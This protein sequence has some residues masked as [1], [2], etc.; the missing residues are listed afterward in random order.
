MDS[1][2]K[3]QYEADKKYIEAFNKKAL[4]KIKEYR[5][6]KIADLDTKR[7]NFIKSGL[8][9][10]P[11]ESDVCPF[12]GEHTITDELKSK[13]SKDVEANS[14]TGELHEKILKALDQLSSR[15]T[16]AAQ[17][18]LPRMKNAPTVQ[19]A[20]PKIRQ[21]LGNESKDL[22]DSLEQSVKQIITESQELNSIMETAQGSVD[23]I[24][25]HFDLIDFDE[26]FV[27]KQIAN[28][29]LFTSKTDSI[30]ENLS[31]YASQYASTKE[32]LESK[33]RKKRCIAVDT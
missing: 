20:I 10:L 6:E 1:A 30:K 29:E 33:M 31:F 11:S 25:T 7:C 2:S 12:C 21:L 22:I 14:K 16:N 23:S 27:Q 9:L 3:K 26:K 24:K 28:I 18:F 15:V 5:S 8:E 17:H 4:E 32:R 13:L 19:D